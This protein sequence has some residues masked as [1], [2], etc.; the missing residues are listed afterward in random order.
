VSSTFLL[1]L[2]TTAPRVTFG[3]AGGT[4][5]GELLQVS[6]T[7][8]EPGITSASIRLADGRTLTLEVLSDRL[9]VLLPVDT[10]DGNATVTVHTLDDVGN[11]RTQTQVVLLHGSIVVPPDQPPDVGPGA[12]RPAPPFEPLRERRR[13]HSVVRSTTRTRIR[14]QQHDDTRIIASSGERITRGIVRSASE[15]TAITRSRTRVRIRDTS[16]VRVTDTTAIAKRFVG[17][18]EEDDLILLGLL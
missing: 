5:A 10:P 9:Q 17:R 6:Y 12:F 13:G 16:R 15:V 4:T 18:G 14:V 11:A 2:D 1:K 8:D 7:I 3:A